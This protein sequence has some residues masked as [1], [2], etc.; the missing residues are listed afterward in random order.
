V[1]KQQVTKGRQRM[2]DLDWHDFFNEQVEAG[3]AEK[4]LEVDEDDYENQLA[5]AKAYQL[6]KRTR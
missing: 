1:S 4:S 6:T 3:C 2:K 5:L